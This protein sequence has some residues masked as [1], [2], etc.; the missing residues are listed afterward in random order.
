M[1]QCRLHRLHCPHLG[2][3]QRPYCVGKTSQTDRELYQ[4]LLVSYR[5]ISVASES[6]RTREVKIKARGNPKG[7]SQRDGGGACQKGRWNIEK[8]YRLAQIFRPREKRLRYSSWTGFLLNWT[9]I[10]GYYLRQLRFRLQ[11]L[12]Y[13][14]QNL[15]HS[16][17][18]DD[19]S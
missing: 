3:K 10:A 8:S 17:L 7:N 18:E 6:A 9:T 2:L 14:F 13:Y 11:M 16:D 12:L 5:W 19:E 15:L 1:L 4:Q